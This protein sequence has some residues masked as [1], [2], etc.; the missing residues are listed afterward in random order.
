MNQNLK[1][2][3]CDSLPNVDIAVRLKVSVLESNV[4]HP[5]VRLHCKTFGLLG[6]HE[7]GDEEGLYGRYNLAR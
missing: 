4:G 5:L 1:L 3:I 2:A 6:S 7:F